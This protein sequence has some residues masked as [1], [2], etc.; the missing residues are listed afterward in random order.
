MPLHVALGLAVDKAADGEGGRGGGSGGG[1][2]RV[3]DEAAAAAADGMVLDV[4]ASAAASHA[5]LAASFRRRALAGG[6]Q[7]AGVGAAVAS[8][9]SAVPGDEGDDSGALPI[10]VTFEGSARGLH[11]EGVDT[12]FVVGPPLLDSGTSSGQLKGQMK[13]HDLL[14]SFRASP[15]S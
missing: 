7:L 12:V 5:E 1:G 11:F 10:L 4:A 13:T 15:T 2:S 8:G 9:A 6:P 14:L 3:G